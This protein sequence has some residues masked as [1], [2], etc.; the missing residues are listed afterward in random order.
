MTPA[1]KLE[2]D[3]NKVCQL[4]LGSYTDLIKIAQQSSTDCYLITE[5]SFTT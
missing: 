2:I 4:F 1:T 5:A 3:Q